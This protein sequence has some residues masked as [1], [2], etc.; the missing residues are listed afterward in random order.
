MIRIRSTA[1]RNMIGEV[2]TGETY[3]TQHCD[4]DVLEQCEEGYLT[5]NNEFADRGKGYAIA[6]Q[7]GQLR[8]HDNTGYLFSFNIIWDQELRR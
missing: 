1:K 6:E 4:I 8:S 5:N 7:A 2:S 3:C